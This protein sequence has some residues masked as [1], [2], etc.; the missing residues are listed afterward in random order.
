MTPKDRKTLKRLLD[1]ERDESYCR[2]SEEIL[3]IE[4]EAAG[5]LNEWN[6]TGKGEPFWWFDNQCG[7]SYH[8][9]RWLACF[10]WNDGVYSG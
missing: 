3:E 10:V 6:R 2:T 4:A 5:L 9:G 1:L 8:Y 7:C